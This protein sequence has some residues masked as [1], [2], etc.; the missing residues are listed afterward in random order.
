MHL[1]NVVV[2]AVVQRNGDDLVQARLVQANGGSRQHVHRIL[3][4]DA[5]RISGLRVNPDREVQLR[6]IRV[7]DVAAQVGGAVAGAQGPA[8]AGCPA[9]QRCQGS[10]LH[11]GM[12]TSVAGNQVGRGGVRAYRSAT[13]SSRRNWSAT[14]GRSVG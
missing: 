14:S 1:G 5:V 8:A 13:P 10:V 6:V 12:I 11:S 3:H 2:D 9:S 7:P 4:Q